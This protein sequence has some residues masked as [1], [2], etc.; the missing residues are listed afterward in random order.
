MLGESQMIA[1]GGRFCPKIPMSE[2]DSAKRF[3]PPHQSKWPEVQVL[4]VRM[5]L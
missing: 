2:G 1:G 3:W 5:D 4:V